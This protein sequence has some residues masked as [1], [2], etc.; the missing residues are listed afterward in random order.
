MK[1]DTKQ[2]EYEYKH[3]LSKKI[4]DKIDDIVCRNAGLDAFETKFIK[5][6]TLKY[7]LNKVEEN[8]E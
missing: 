4:I 5:N 7:R 1:I 6:Y 3:K 2:T 8:E